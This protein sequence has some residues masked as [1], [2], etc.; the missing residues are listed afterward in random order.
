MNLIKTSLILGIGLSAAMVPAQEEAAD[1]TASSGLI[2][3]NR[4]DEERINFLIEVANVY[5]KEDD[6]LSAMNAYERI[7]EIDPNNHEARY[8]IAHVYINA[9]VYDKAEAGLLELIE[10][11]PEDFK[12]KNNLAWMYATAED[13]KY[14]NGKKAVR[15]AQEALVLAPDDHHVWSTLSEAHYINGDY[16]KAYNA[17]KT[18]AAKAAKYAQGVT[19]EQVDDYNEQIRKC[20]RAWDTQKMLQEAEEE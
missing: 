15:F 18:M 16:E 20:K 17:I 12:L 11:Y 8:T 4:T 19:K 9:K 1:A 2:V 6:F 14:R 7:L 13:P 5:F 3:N 10:L